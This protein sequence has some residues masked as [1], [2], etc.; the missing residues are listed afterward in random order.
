MRGAAEF[1]NIRGTA[2]EPVRPIERPAARPGPGVVALRPHR[3]MMPGLSGV[4]GMYR[5]ILVS[6]FLGLLA[7]ALACAGLAWLGASDAR[8]HLERTRLSHEVLEAHIQLDVR[9]YKL[10]KQ[11]TDT[12][13]THGA[14][15]LDQAAA[16]RRLADQFE[17]V[18][19]A[20]AR[21]VSFVG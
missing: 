4:A 17:A 2:L 11:L 9:A 1:F 3:G 10:F 5:T 12:L 6:T 18:R 15:K 7:I 19:H 13:L 21:E 16:Q 14:R 8:Y 20:I